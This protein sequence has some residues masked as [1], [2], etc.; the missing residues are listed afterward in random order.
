MA[1]TVQ[2]LLND[3][4]GAVHGTTLNKIPNLFGAINRAASAVLLDVDPKETQRILQISSQVFNSVYDY[5]A[6]DDVKGDRFIDIRPQAGRLPGEQFTQGY[7]TDFDLFKGISWD[8]KIYTQWNT[9]LKTMRI[10]APFLTS[11]VTLTDTSS[12]LGWTAGDDASNIHLDTNNAV[13][14]GGALVFDLAFNAGATDGFI[15]NSTLTPIDY[16]NYLNVSN[17]FLWVYL[18]N[19]TPVTDVIAYWGSSTS[20]YY[21]SEIRPFNG[22][23]LQNGWNLLSCEWDQATFVGSPDV[24]S[25][26]YAR[27]QVQ[28]DGTAQTGVKICNFTFN[29]GYIFDAVYYSKFLFRDPTTGAFVE[30]IDPTKTDYIIN[31]D[32]DSWPLLFNKT[33]YYIA[34]QLQGA[35]AD[36]DASFWGGEDGQGGE[37]GVALARY[38]ALNPSESMVKAAPYY[39]IGS[40]NYR[41]FFGNGSNQG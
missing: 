32:T 10:Q 25:M 8:N 33:A 2:L 37:Y 30:R 34:Q 3:I 17:G 16:T 6:P 19:S 18:P 1:Y 12:T 29:L 31:L 38:S 21:S 35:D 9:G 28:Y 13:A 15:E 40:K 5:P 20:D 24:S 39:Q 36:Y 41:N 14:G 22:G 26:D 11:P 27:V 23:S 7:G 4:A